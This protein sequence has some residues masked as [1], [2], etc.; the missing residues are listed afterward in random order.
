MK[1]AILITVLVCLANAVAIQAQTESN[2]QKTSETGVFNNQLLF[3]PFY[4]FDQT[5]MVSYERI[6]QGNGALRITPS[7]TLSNADRFNYGNREGFGLDL[8]YKAFLI[9]NQKNRMT[10]FNVYLGPYIMYRNIKN[11]RIQPEAFNV[12]GGGID[13]GIK[14]TFGHRFVLDITVGGGIR[15][16]SIKGGFSSDGIFDDAFKGIAPR[17][18]LFLGA[19]L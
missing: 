15:N 17:I 4:F 12:L 16:P 2:F 6:F 1:R 14:F 9:T 13:T 18:N 19:T 10:L 7:F 11:P 5:L 3:A 8:G